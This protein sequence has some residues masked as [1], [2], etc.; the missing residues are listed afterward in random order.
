MVHRPE[1]TSMALLEQV[2]NRNLLEANKSSFEKN[3]GHLKR[4]PF[5]CRFSPSR[6]LILIDLPEFA[7]HEY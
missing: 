1:Q 7:G 4:M 5:F 2:H 3:Q 6:F